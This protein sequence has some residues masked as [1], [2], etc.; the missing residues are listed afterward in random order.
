MSQIDEFLIAIAVALTL[1]VLSALALYAPLRRVLGLV[2]G[3]DV[4]AAFWTG[5]SALFLV[6]LPVLGVTTAIWFGGH[7]ISATE[8]LSRMVSVAI[9]FLVVAL[10]AVG[11]ELKTGI[12]DQLAA[13]QDSRGTTPNPID[14]SQSHPEPAE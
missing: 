12:R 14:G 7:E 3:N 10:F 9:A 2:C 8:A 5:Y 13:K 11:R 6:L 1:G 4:G